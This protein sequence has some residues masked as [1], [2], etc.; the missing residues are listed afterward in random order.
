[1]ASFAAEVHRTKF[2][3]RLGRGDDL[4]SCRISY[5]SETRAKMVA[6]YPVGSANRARIEGIIKNDQAVL[7]IFSRM[8]PKITTEG[9]F[10]LAT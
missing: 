5:T 7:N 1:M 4:T 10:R 9:R 6:I 8:T 2:L 3:E